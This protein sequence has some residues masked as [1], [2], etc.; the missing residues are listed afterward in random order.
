MENKKAICNDCK[1]VIRVP[2]ERHLSIIEDYQCLKTKDVDYV[3]GKE[4]FSSCKDVNTDGQCELFQR[5][6]K[7]QL[8]KDEIAKL[9]E[10]HRNA[11]NES[12]S[13]MEK[14]FKKF[15]EIKEMNI[16]QFMKY[17]RSYRR[18]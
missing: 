16:I 8:L 14:M 1:N 9:R 17:K 12:Y 13:E 7:E 2:N 10:D 15:D 18:Y 4:M 5:E 6:D 3:T 11:R